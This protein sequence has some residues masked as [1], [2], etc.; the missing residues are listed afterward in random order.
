MAGAERAFWVLVRAAL[1]LAL[2]AE[3]AFAENKTS[4]L[5]VRMPEQISVIVGAAQNAL[6]MPPAPEQVVEWDGCLQFQPEKALNETLL[7]YVRQVLRKQIDEM[8]LVPDDPTKRA[9]VA[10]SSV[11]LTGNGRRDLLVSIVDSIDCYGGCYMFAL[12]RKAP[13]EPIEINYT[14]GPP[15]AEDVPCVKERPAANG[16]PSLEVE[17]ELLL[18]CGPPG[19][20]TFDT[21]DP[22][23]GAA[24]F[25]RNR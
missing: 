3:T 7:D 17:G 13:L 23:P 20:R 9:R 24:P 2:F 15:D 1:V 22:S 12:L 25:R 18:L 11:D 16:A 5:P 10:V 8:T 14:R 19:S 4:L 6:L 21:C